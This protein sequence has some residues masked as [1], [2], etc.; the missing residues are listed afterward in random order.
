MLERPGWQDLKAVKEGNFYINTAFMSRSWKDDRSCLH[1]KM[2]V[3][4]SDD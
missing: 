3:S 1:G 4:G 2:A